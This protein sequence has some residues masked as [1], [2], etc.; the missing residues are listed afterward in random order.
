MLL[1]HDFEPVEGIFDKGALYTRYR[2]TARF[3]EYVYAGV[4]NDPKAIEAWIKKRLLA[5]D[6]YMRLVLVEALQDLGHEVDTTATREQIIEAAER[7]AVLKKGCAFR[8]NRDGIC[9]AA[10]NA[11]A[12]LKEACNIVYPYG[13]GH[14]WGPKGKK[15]DGGEYGG[16]TPRKVLAEWVSVDDPMIPLGQQEPDGTYMHVG[17]PQGKATLTYFEFAVQP[18]IAFHVWSHEDRVTREQWERILVCGEEQGMGA[19]RSMEH[20]K[21]RVV[22]FDKV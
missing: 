5:D 21:F 8:R 16:K 6:E 4:P 2:V 9:L 7:I 10:Y 11:K 12:M 14:R 3:R 18:T 20:G 15:A 19:I 1:H 13:D 22:G 17:H